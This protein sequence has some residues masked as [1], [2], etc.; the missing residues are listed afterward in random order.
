MRL[1]GYVG[2][3]D[4]SQ[5]ARAVV[6]GEAA[7]AEALGVALAARL[8]HAGADEILSSLAAGHAGE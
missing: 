8:R 2:S 1:R 6:S 4:G 7:E 3:P 5:V